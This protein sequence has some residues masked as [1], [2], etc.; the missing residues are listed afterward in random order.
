MGRHGPRRQQRDRNG[1]PTSPPPSGIAAF[2]IVKPP[3]VAEDEIASS[4]FDKLVGYL[5]A[6]GDLRQSHEL[7]IALLAGEW[8]RHV[9]AARIA[10]ATPIIDGP[11][12]AKAHPACG[13][14]AAAARVARD[15]LSEL[16]LTPASLSRCDVPQRPATSSVL[17]KFRAR[18]DAARVSPDDADLTPEQRHALLHGTV[19]EQAA[20]RRDVVEDRRMLGTG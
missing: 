15:L 20:A 5:A 9:A 14:A 18:R 16:G 3:H 7:P 1:L 12:G 10:R 19:A 11:R 2:D 13:I 4:V 6:R 17:D 8:S